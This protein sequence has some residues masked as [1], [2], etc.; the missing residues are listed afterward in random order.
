MVVVFDHTIKQLFEAENS[1]SKRNGPAKVD[2]MKAKDMHFSN[3]SIL[4]MTSKEINTT[5]SSIDLVNDYYPFIDFQL[6]FP[7]IWPKVEKIPKI[8]IIVLVNSGA[9]GEKFRRNREAIRETWGNQSNCEQRQAMADERLKDLRW[10]LVFVIGKAGPET[11]DD[12]LNMAE[13]RKY[14][15]ML[16]G[17]IADNYLNNIVKLYMGLVWASG[18]DTKYVLK[19]DDDV[20]VRVP[21]VLEYLVKA[22]SRR[23]FYGGSVVKRSPVQ[24]KIGNKWT[25]SYKHYGKERYPTYHA[26]AFFILSNDLLNKLFNYVYKRIPF[27]IDDAYVGLAMH[28]IGVKITKIPSFI[29]KEKVTMF[30]RKTKDCMISPP[31][32]AGHNADPRISKQFHGRIKKPACEQEY[33]PAP[34]PKKRQKKKNATSPKTTPPSQKSQNQ[35]YITKSF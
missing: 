31:A 33:T 15:D 6:V 5:L 13:A 26:G 3:Q 22:K 17:N 25:I 8:F 9:K 14:N 11:N 35:N 29:I 10:I 18:F 4:N 1:I 28:H 32:A 34:R 24:R 2:V 19:T 20:Y 23:P 12:E 30:L 7:A 16:I 21:R 27:H